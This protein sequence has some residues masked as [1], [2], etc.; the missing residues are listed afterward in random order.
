ME[1]LTNITNEGNVESRLYNSLILDL[2]TSYSYSEMS[3]EAIQT[4]EVLIKRDPNNSVGLV[5][6]GINYY[7]IND[8]NNACINFH[9]ASKLGNQQAK[10]LILQLNCK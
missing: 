8:I 1:Y 10:N 6:L 2:G 7:R 5:N 9:K 3:K 4:F